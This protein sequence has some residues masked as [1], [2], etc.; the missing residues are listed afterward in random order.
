M[1]IADGGGALDGEPVA[2]FAPT[3]KLLDEVW[4]EGRR[5]L[6]PLATRIDSQQHRIELVTGGSLDFWTLDDPDAGRG[7][8]YA[9]IVIDEA[10]MARYLAEAWQEAIRPT[11]TDLQGSAW[12]FS[13]PKGRNNEF[14]RLFERAAGRPDWARWQM[15]TWTNP[16]IARGEIEAARRDLPSLVF[17][18]EYEAEF[19]DQQGAVLRREW[20]RRGRAPDGCVLSMGVDLA[21]ST[22]EDADF[23][24]AVVLARA[25]DGALFVVDAARIRAPFHQVLAFI[26][27]MADRHRPAIIAI[28]SVQYQAAVVQELLRTTSL[29]VRGVK[30]DRD[31][32]T[33]F[34]PLQ[35]R[36]EQGQVAHAPGLPPEFED[37]LLSFP[38]GEHDDMADALAYAFAALPQVGQQAAAA[39]SR[40]FGGSHALPL[41]ASL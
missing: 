12:F 32:L 28:E 41:A 1:L 10:A 2:W 36:Y 16:H 5:R 14:A 40:I 23:T 22:R 18:Q 15:P 11:L 8:K 13:T 7:R 20:I 33:R 21:L 26:R 27:G 35:A 34:L 38:V 39:G 37:E 19:I 24:A 4:R 3:Y 9:R 25:P 6:R 30:P 17:R 29:P 31:K